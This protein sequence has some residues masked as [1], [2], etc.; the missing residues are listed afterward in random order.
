MGEKLLDEYLNAVY[1]ATENADGNALGQL[2]SLQNPRWFVRNRAAV[3]EDAVDSYLSP[4]VG[5]FVLAHM[6]AANSIHDSDWLKAFEHQCAMVAAITKW[7]QLQKD[8][9]W[10][11][12]VM[13]TACVELRLLALQAERVQKRSHSGAQVEFLEKAADCL[14][15]CFRICASDNRTSEEATKRWGMLA[16]INQL[17]KVYFRINKLN[18]CKPLIRAIESS[19]FKEDFSLG[20]QVT[21]RYYTGRKAMFDS[22]YRLAEEYLEYSFQHCHIQSRKNKRRILIYLIPVKM[23]LGYM[24]KRALLEK[25]DLM[26]FWPAAQ[27]IREGNSNGLSRAI[28][29]HEA[30]FIKNGVYIMLEKL[31]MIAFRNLFKKVY[32][33]LNSHQIDIAAL[34]VALKFSGVSDADMDETQCLV[35]NLIN[36]NK[37]KGYISH[38]HNKLVVSKQNPFPALHTVA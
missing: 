28:E 20:Q 35:A 21:Y 23:L 14:M 6:H 17:F 25:Y 10:S 22:E 38:Q 30:F 3:N 16:L 27:A 4:P 33:I 5:E 36:D 24:P 7:L 29:K 15:A 37:I 11:L 32:H 9:N 12:P 13:H 19:P 31:R 1:E 18:L 2:V 26:A 34:N 8:E